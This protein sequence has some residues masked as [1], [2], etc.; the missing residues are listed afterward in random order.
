VTLLL[1]PGVC[2]NVVGGL[3]PVAVAK[4]AEVVGLQHAM[5]LAPSCYV[6]SGLLFLL[7]E[8]EIEEQTR[9]ERELLGLPAPQQ[10]VPAP[11]PEASN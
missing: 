8:K 5:L 9:K 3:G 4:L 1:W 10:G 2:R 11:V 7:A 6:M